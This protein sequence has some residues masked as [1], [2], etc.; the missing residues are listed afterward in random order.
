MQRIITFCLLLSLLF[1]PAPGDSLQ[2]IDELMQHGTALAELGRYEQAAAAFDMVTQY[3]PNF[4]DAWRKKG[5]SFLS[6][7]QYRDALLAYDAA[8]ELNSDDVASLV[9]AGIALNA[10]HQYQDAISMFD[11]ALA[12]DPENMAAL[13]NKAL[14]L[15]VLGRNEEALPLYSHALETNHDNPDT[16]NNLGLSLSS[17]GRVNES[18]AAFDTIIRKFPT[19]TEAWNNKGLDFLARGQ[20]DEANEMFD[21]ATRLQ[22]DDPI[23]WN[24]K[25][26]ALFKSGASEDARLAYQMSVSL[27]T[28]SSH[29]ASS[30][31]S[32]NGSNPSTEILADI[33]NLSS[34]DATSAESWNLL[35]SMFLSHNAYTEA[36]AAYE[37]ALQLDPLS[38]VAREYFSHSPDTGASDGHFVPI[39][40]DEGTSCFNALTNDQA[41]DLTGEQEVTGTVKYLV[42]QQGWKITLPGTISGVVSAQTGKMEITSTDAFIS[43]GGTKYPIVMNIEGSLR[44]PGDGEE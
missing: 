14:S 1:T 23:Y 41:G 36:D 8:L 33:V 43:Y 30:A 38:Q 29:R 37:R 12:I 32:E 19:Y 40:P 9:D 24:N 22:P 28:C 26:T 2:N 27:H 35:G 17:M 20:Y 25:G 31:G 11:R 3:D 6:A 7:G 18:M 5:Y 4:T 44:N 16:L 15:M 34:F 10:L 42:E 39:P 21:M 13:N